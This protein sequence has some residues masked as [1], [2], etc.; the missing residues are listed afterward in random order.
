MTYIDLPRALEQY[1]AFAETAPT[2]NGRR[3]SIN[4]PYLNGERVDRLQWWYHVSPA[5]AHS[6]TDEK[7]A[8]L[9][10]QATGLF[11]RHIERWLVNTGQRLYGDEPFPRIGPIPVIEI[12]M[13]AQSATAEHTASG[14]D[15]ANV[16]AWPAEKV[17]NG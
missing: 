15:Q 17:A 8:A 7:L 9:K 11:R 16:L 1:F 13:A 10:A 3:F 14:P 4:L 5:Q 6:V 2:R 12:E